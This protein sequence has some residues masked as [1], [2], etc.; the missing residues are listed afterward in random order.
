M[1]ELYHGLR[2]LVVVHIPVATVA[3]FRVPSDR[4]KVHDMNVGTNAGIMNDCCGL[5]TMLVYTAQRKD[6]MSPPI[7][8]STKQRT[9]EP[10]LVNVPV[11]DSEIPQFDLNI[12]NRVRT[13]LF[14]WN[15]QFSPQFIEA[16]I[17]R[18]VREGDTVLDPFVGS[19][20]TVYECAR[21]G[22]AVYGIELNPSAFFMAK[23]YEL[24]H[25]DSQERELLIRTVGSIVNTC[26][27]E[28]NVIS[29]ILEFYSGMEESAIKSTVALL[30]TLLD[31]YN[32]AVD[33]KLLF[34]KWDK[35]RSI[36]RSLPFSNALIQV[37]LGDARYLSIPD[38]TIDAVLTS[39]PYINV[40]NYHQ[41]YRRSIE[42]LGYDILEIAKSEL[43]ANRKHRGNRFYTVIQ[44]CIDMALAVRELSRVC[45][46]D[47]RLMLVVGRESN[48]LGHSFYNSDLVYQ[49]C[50]EIFRLSFDIRQERVFKNKFGKLIYEDI[51]HFRNRKDSLLVDEELLCD[52]ARDIAKRALLAKCELAN[53]DNIIELLHKAV[54][55]A[56]QILPSEASI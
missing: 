16:L 9:S 44:Y 11:D 3:G 24:C 40:F 25:A 54:N 12:E 39:P 49:I 21:A 10:Y 13:N 6:G 17:Q 19:G 38:N 26:L 29:K 42:A 50:T 18:F 56:S 52:G 5:M 20:T 37:S 51:L 48:V 33:S 8:I 15:G 53:D 36:I 4:D 23:L 46:E 43:G 22:I 45:K 35:L 28:E 55:N 1:F 32:N 2:P 41:N 47:T 30:V 7:P 27:Y 34:E 31:I 14:S